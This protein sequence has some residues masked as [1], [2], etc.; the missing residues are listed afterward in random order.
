MDGIQKIF[1]D[2]DGGLRS[3]WRVAVFLFFY[4][5]V[6]GVL[7]LGMS[8]V[9]G[10]LGPDEA[11]P[12]YMLWLWSSLLGLVVALI[13]GWQC[14]KWLEALPF[15]VLGV[16]FRGRWLVHLLVGLITGAATVMFA[17]AIAFAF[18]GERFELNIYSGS[19]NV[20]T[21][22][23]VSFAVFAI[24]AAAEEALFRGYILQTLDHAGF[25]WIAVVLTSVFFGIVHLGNPNAGAISTL[26]TILAGI[27]FSVAYL[28]FRSLW[29]VMG[30]HCAWNWVQGS[31]FGIEVSGM[32]EITQHTLLREIDAGPTWL[33]GETY[34]IEGGI[35]TTI[36]IV[37]SMTLIAFV[38]RD[39]ASDLPEAPGF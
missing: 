4:S 10:A 18:G 32:R 16:S 20:V 5:L 30:M 13:V 27:W 38:K 17:V 3:G 39:S 21:S 12:S 22:M 29:F 19:E 33:T 8:S 25:A 34:G 37:L 24:A 31:V 6:V 15:A 2:E 23:L 35:A 7:V 11:T 1:L 36:A 26:N 9:L 14:G 28:R